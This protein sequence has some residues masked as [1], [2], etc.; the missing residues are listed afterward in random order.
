MS[1]PSVS[2]VICTYNRGPFLKELIESIEREWTDRLDAELIVV[3]NNCTDNTAE[4]V[5]AF[6]ASKTNLRRVVE[7]NQGLSHARNC[8]ARESTK[9]YILYL[10][11][12]ATLTEGYLDRLEVVLRRFNPDLFGGPVLPRFDRPLPA[13]FNPKSEIRQFERISCFTKTGSVSGGNFGI[14]R[15]LVEQMQGFNTSL[16]MNGGEMAFGEDREM[17]ERYRQA[18]PKDQQKIYYAV[19]LPIVHYTM[20]YKYDEKYQYERKRKNARAQEIT[21][22]RTGKRSSLQALVLALGHIVYYPF[23]ALRIGLQRKFDAEYS[24]LMVRHWHGVMGR[25]EGALRARLFPQLGGVKKAAQ[26]VVH[27]M[28]KAAPKL[29]KLIAKPFAK[30][31]FV[32]RKAAQKGWAL[33]KRAGSKLRAIVRRVLFGRAPVVEAVGE[34]PVREVV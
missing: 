17:V 22:I 9:E 11:D 3:D 15:A 16:G 1:K 24:Y 31:L 6:D 19:E 7:T 29:R 13:W 5:A 32:A 14:K 33:I 28:R 27:G 2:V 8:G 10:D 30:L 23:Y 21:F 34:E 18:T 20:P 26:R 12:D 4:I 25:L